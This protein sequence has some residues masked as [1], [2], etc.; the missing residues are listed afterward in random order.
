MTTAKRDTYTPETLLT[1][2][3][4]IFNE[5]GYDGTSM[6][7]LSQAAGISKSSIYHHVAGKEELLRRAVSRALDGLFGILD[8]SGAQR[9][10]AVERVE[11]VVRRT[12][13][14]LVADLPYV[15]L[16]LRVRGNTK[17]ERWAMERRREFDHRVVELLRAAA[18]EGDLRTDVDTRL[19]TRL[20][21]G[22]VNSLVE[23]YRPHPGGGWEGDQVAETVVRIAFDGLRTVNGAGAGAAGRPAS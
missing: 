8:E 21:F 23:W 14:V 3:V 18:A 5:R 2:A 6:E 22:M 4:R 19:A 1:V 7:H 13:Q 10:R 20:L 16:L 17:T 9:G 12:V 15:T 11:Y